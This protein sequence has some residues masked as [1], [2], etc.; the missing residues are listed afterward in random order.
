VRASAIGRADVK[1]CRLLVNDADH[2][3]LDVRTKEEFEE[4]SVHGSVN[5]P[6]F[7]RSPSGMELN[8][9]FVDQVQEVRATST[10]SM[11]C[12]TS[13]E[14]DHIVIESM[15]TGSAMCGTRP[16]P[17]SSW[18]PCNCTILV[19]CCATSRACQKRDLD[20]KTYFP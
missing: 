18:K 8:P 11:Q 2:K 19:A 10:L 4:S 5:V 12:V 14:I 6:V 7:F 16:K 15:M 3:Y 13:S 17:C 9:S 1:Q 20:P